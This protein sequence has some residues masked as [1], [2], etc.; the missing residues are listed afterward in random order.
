MTYLA[1]AIGGALGATARYG[2]GVLA[3]R[4]AGTALPWGTLGV[5]LIGSLLIGIVGTLAIDF[6]AFSNAQRQFLIA[7]VLGGFTTFSSLSFELHAFIRDGLYGK[8]ALYLALS[9]GVG[10]A[11][12]AAGSAIARELRS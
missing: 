1:V 4:Y 10:L 11:A 2:V 9:V 7:G 6:A 8:A 3:L 5:N 12:V